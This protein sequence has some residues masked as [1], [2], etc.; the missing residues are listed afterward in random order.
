MKRGKMPMKPITLFLGAVFLLLA[1]FPGLA[2]AETVMVYVRYTA[3]TVTDED[4]AY[5]IVIPLED[6]IMNE[7]FDY[8]HIVF[9]SGVEKAPALPFAGERESLRMAKSGGAMF[10]LEVQV[11]CSPAEDPEKAP[12]SEGNENLKKAGSIDRH[13]LKDI[14]FQFSRVQNGKVIK[15]G[16]MPPNKVDGPKE[17]LSFALG[18]RIARMVL[19]DWK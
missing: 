1:A 12:Q 13:E 18:Q 17:E 9:N 6:G 7:F 2:E 15:K 19:H 10:L 11:V 16:K 8:G 14:F 4:E 3:A 5:K